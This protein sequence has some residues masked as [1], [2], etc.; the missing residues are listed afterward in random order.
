MTTRFTLTNL[1]NKHLIAAHLTRTHLTPVNQQNSS[2]VLTIIIDR[3]LQLE[4]SQTEPPTKSQTS[5]P[6]FREIIVRRG[7]GFEVYWLRE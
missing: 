2:S 7:V 4:S 6:K 3:E 1:A 5:P